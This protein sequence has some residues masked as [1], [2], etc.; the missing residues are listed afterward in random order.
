MRFPWLPSDYPNDERTMLRA[1][2][3]CATVRQYAAA[4]LKALGGAGSLLALHLRIEPD[5]QLIRAQGSKNPSPRQLREFL[6]NHV[7]PLAKKH[8]CRTVYIC[9]GRVADEYVSILEAVSATGIKIFHKHDPSLANSLPTMPRVVGLQR[10]EK[11]K[12]QDHY[13]S[14]AD[15]LVM[16]QAKVAIVTHHSSMRYAVLAWRCG[17]QPSDTGV[18]TIGIRA[19][20]EITGPRYFACGGV[21]KGWMGHTDPDWI[22]N[23]A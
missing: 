12:T 5:S 1:M 8:H 13:T 2:V 22:R 19:K 15:L 21:T 11:Q 23:D 10:D 16:S 3:P 17:G 6:M 4:V 20:G 7:V 9:T 14:L 18:Y